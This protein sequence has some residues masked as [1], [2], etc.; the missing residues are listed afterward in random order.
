M[1]MVPVVITELVGTWMIMIEVP[2]RTAYAAVTLHDHSG[3]WIQ[4]ID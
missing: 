4:S 3:S 1:I 2:L